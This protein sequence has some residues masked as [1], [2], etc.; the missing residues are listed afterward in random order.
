MKVIERILVLIDFSAFS[1][2]ALDEAVEFSRPYETE[3][4][5]LFVVELGFY[6]SP[7]LVPD[8][9]ALLKHQAR[10]TEEKLE[11]ICR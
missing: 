1:L 4:V 7:L 6:E 9:E 5:L 8:S 10:A 11:E 3:L 2:K